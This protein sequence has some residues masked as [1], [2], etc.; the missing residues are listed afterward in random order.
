MAIFYVAPYGLLFWGPYGFCKWDPYGSHMGS[1]YEFNMGPIW[2]QHGLY[3]GPKS[4]AGRFN[5]AL[6]EVY[7]GPT[8]HIHG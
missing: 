5:L 1:P 2:V 4:H 7:M 8:K 3:M 6:N